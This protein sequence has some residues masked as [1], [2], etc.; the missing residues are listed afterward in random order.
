MQLFM[1]FFKKP[2]TA[3]VPENKSPNLNTNVQNDNSNIIVITYRDFFT[4][5]LFSISLIFFMSCILGLCY[6]VIHQNQKTEN[7]YDYDYSSYKFNIRKR[8]L[9]KSDQEMELN[10]ETGELYYHRPRQKAENSWNAIGK[11]ITFTPGE[12]FTEFS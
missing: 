10:S 8:D 9:E 4:K 2:N 11:N 12:N 6:I 3:N 1:G 7:D 5:T